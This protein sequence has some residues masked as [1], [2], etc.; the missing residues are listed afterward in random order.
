MET[1]IKIIYAIFITQ[2]WINSSLFL[3]IKDKLNLKSDDYTSAFKDFFVE[4]L[5]CA[6]CSGFWIGA[7]ILTIPLN[8]VVHFL[9]VA[10]IVAIISEF[11]SRKLNS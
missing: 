4:L 7:I 8:D 11:V 6:M 2:I 9:G 5:T 10:S 1:I 3:M